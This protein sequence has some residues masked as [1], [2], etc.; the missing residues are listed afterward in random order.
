MTFTSLTF[1]FLFLP[2]A[3]VGY[4]VI[5][6][7]MPN[8]RSYYLIAL[9]LLFY[10]WGDAKSV[11]V[12]L[13][14]VL[15]H[16]AAGQT[17]IEWKR[18]ENARY[19]KLSLALAIIVD[20][21]VLALFKYTSIGL[22]L[23]ISFY[24]FSAISYLV[25]VYRGERERESFVDEVLYITFF[26]KI[27]SGPIVRYE[28]FGKSM[29]DASSV[30]NNILIGTRCFVIGMFK[31]VLLADSFGASFQAIYGLPK[32]AGMTAWLGMLFYG[33]QLYFDFSGYSDMAI[34]VA[35]ILGFKFDKNFDDPYTS[36]SIA[37]FWR[38]WHISL[39]GW[40]RNYV[41]IPLGGNR[42]S[43]WKQVRNLSVVWLMT[44][45]WHGST[46]NFLLWG[47][48]HGCFIL[49]ERFV[50]GARRDK[51][52]EVV[53]MIVTDV[54]V[55]FGW[56]AF[57]TPSFGAMVQWFG[58]MFGGDGLGLFDQTTGYYLYNNLILLIFAV[59]CSGSVMRKLYQELTL[60]R[61]GWAMY[62]SV[63]AHAILVL[64]CFANMVGATYHSF[65]YF[66]F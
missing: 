39:G 13:L 40:F 26:P 60:K 3:L 38:R 43:Q 50:I 53:Q 64:F 46:W 48:Y 41:Y 61:D 21:A 65:L 63:A 57:F 32:M 62:V 28:D 29:Q 27:V 42:C 56:T 9:S 11:P 14:S 4:F 31:K 6:Y 54:I 8:C 25:D 47:V 30:R 58:R 2:L 7:K 52:P 5:F 34:G 33:F 23:G 59:L 16:Y 22:P 66:K 10:A 12:L 20:V 55:F 49:L 1:L 44:G 35:R 45:I 24:T 17:M 18:R 37:E 36:K 19:A 51:V 15:F